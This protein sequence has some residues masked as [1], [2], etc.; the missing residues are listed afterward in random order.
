MINP[1]LDVI[2]LSESFARNKSIQ[3]FDFLKEDKA[4]EL[5]EWFNSNI[6][7]EWWFTSVMNP[8]AE[9]YKGADNI[10]NKPEAKEDINKKISKANEA[11]LNGNFSYVF[12]RSM[13]H[14]AKCNCLECQFLEFLDSDFMLF[15]VKN[16]TGVEVNRKKEVFSSRFMPGHFLSPHH[17]KDKGKIGFVYSLSKSW[18]PEWGGNLHFMEEDYRTVTKTIVPVFNRLT[19]FDI[20]T[21]DGVP[22]YVSHVL[23]HVKT[24]RISITG[25][26]A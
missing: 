22:H 19:M 14:A 17:D 13:P 9:G 1:A 26:F 10:Q 16:I 4:N 18:R 3:V 20:P 5:Y 15:L 21:R 12:D 6:P 11:F 24:K 25:W 8:L 23:P 2:E 7:E